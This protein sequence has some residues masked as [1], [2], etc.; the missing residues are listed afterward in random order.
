MIEQKDI[1]IYASKM[2]TFLIPQTGALLQNGKCFQGKS[3]RKVNG[4]KEL[5][6]TGLKIVFIKIV[7]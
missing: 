6:F 4:E 5:A 2:I 7:L 1:Y 3:I